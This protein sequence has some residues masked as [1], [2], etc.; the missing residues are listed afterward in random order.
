MSKRCLWTFLV[1]LALIGSIFL[2][3]WLR[4]SR[5][6]PLVYTTTSPLEAQKVITLMRYHGA[7][8]AR[9][10]DGRWYFLARNGRW[11]PLDTQEACRYLAARFN[12]E[13][14]APCL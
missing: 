11:L 1:V 4:L 12:Q 5:Q 2:G 6:N 10:K 7:Q 9:L 3:L 13:Q 14:D 8:V